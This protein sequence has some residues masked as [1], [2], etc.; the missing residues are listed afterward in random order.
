MADNYG[1]QVSGGQVTG[2]SLAAGPR[3]RATTYGTP[4]PDGEAP[5]HTPV[6]H[7]PVP[8]KER[9]VFVIHGRDEQARLRVFDL[10]RRMGL[11]PLEWE[12]LV[13]ET[14]TMSPHLL[15]VV[16]RAFGTAQAVV[17]VMTPDD[18][19]RLHPELAGDH[20]DHDQQ[21]QPRPNV[22]FEAGLAFGVAPARTVLLRLGR[23]RP[24]SDIAGLNHVQ[25]DGSATSVLKI[26]QRLETAGCRLSGTG[27]D[28]VEPSLLRDLAA[29]TRRP[30]RRGR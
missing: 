16:G 2:S 22:L 3:A 26:R 1:I 25:F 6:G 18:I 21:C 27:V 10:L 5:E 19:V 8:E 9:K 20:G 29:Y 13:R 4:P 30:P 14:A 15:D 17:V 7:A 11:E 28:Y 24:F 23:V 12:T